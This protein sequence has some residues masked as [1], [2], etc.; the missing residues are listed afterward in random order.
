[1]PP[2]NSDTDTLETVLDH[3]RLD[4]APDAPTIHAGFQGD[5]AETHNLDPRIWAPLKVCPQC[6][7]AWESTGEW[8]PSCGTAF[9]RSSERVK[10]TRVMPAERQR[11]RAA[12]GQRSRRPGE[13]PLSRSGR[14][15]GPPPRARKQAAPAPKRGGTG[16]SVAKGFA[17][18]AVFAVAVTAAFYIGQQS[19][20]S[21]SDLDNATQQAADTARKSAAESLRR[22]QD[23][24]RKQRDAAVARARAQ[25]RSEGQAEAQATAETSD[26]LIDKIS[27]CVVDFSC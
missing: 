11:A 3:T 24:L 15:N 9:D 12:S 27:R 26:S 14:R 23:E 18:L 7:M 19:R 17:L 2:K 22:F 10:A 16:A 25:G 6:S 20:P 21:Q 4:D 1:M 8:C 5:D 13:P